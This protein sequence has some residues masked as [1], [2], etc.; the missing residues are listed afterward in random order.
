M[1]NKA[2]EPYVP[3]TLGVSQSMGVGYTVGMCYAEFLDGTKSSGFI[4]KD[5]TKREVPVEVVAMLKAVLVA[6]CSRI[7]ERASACRTV[8]DAC[9][10][11]NSKEEFV[12]RL[13]SG[14]PFVD[15]I[16]QAVK[17]AWGL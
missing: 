11:A 12:Q 4:E 16:S 2:P 17:G 6:G 14:D 5:G 9:L 7:E 13:P 1:L 10:P 8:F 3:K 15:E